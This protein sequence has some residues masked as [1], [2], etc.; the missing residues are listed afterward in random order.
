MPPFGWN[1]MRSCNNK[2]SFVFREA[3]SDTENKSDPRYSQLE[4]SY[5]EPLENSHPPDQKAPVG[6]LRLFS[7][8]TFPGATSQPAAQHDPYWTF[9][10]GIIITEWFS[11]SFGPNVKLQRT[12]S[13]A[14]QSQRKVYTEP[15]Q[16]GL[17]QIK[18]NFQKTL[19]EVPNAWL[20]KVTFILI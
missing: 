1:H 20:A 17:F 5:K 4:A 11:F 13:F 10:D 12:K 19:P 14:F 3:N 15:N 6:N 16:W 9:S 7:L 18:H 2:T 8:S